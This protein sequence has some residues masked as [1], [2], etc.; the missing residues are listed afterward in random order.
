MS[1]STSTSA[2]RTNCSPNR[3]STPM[4]AST[5][6]STSQSRSTR[7]SCCRWSSCSS[8]SRTSSSCC[9]SCSFR[10]RRS[11]FRRPRHHP[12]SC[13]HHHLRSTRTH[14][15]TCGSDRARFD[16]QTARP[17]SRSMAAHRPH[18]NR[19]HAPGRCHFPRRH[20]HP[21][22]N[23]RACSCAASPR[24]WSTERS[25]DSAGT[26]RSMAPLRPTG[27]PK[28]APCSPCPRSTGAMSDRR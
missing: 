2:G 6:S 23:R 3:R 10:R 17:R 13:H 14:W 24:H 22:Q 9:S 7:S 18:T 26:R 19:P 21:R 8:S 5:T 16:H 15:R 11:S 28:T 27:C 1:A 25:S 20:R 12:S 4:R